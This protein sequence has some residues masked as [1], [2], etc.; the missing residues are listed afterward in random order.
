MGSNAKAAIMRIGL[1]EMKTFSQEFFKGV[2]DATFVSESAG[3]ADLITSCQSLYCYVTTQPEFTCTEL[4]GISGRN[5]KVADAFAKTG[6]VSRP[7]CM[8]FESYSSTER[9][10]S[11]T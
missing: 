2:K 4:T 10:R 8:T 6:K 5:R 9:S 3:V 11:K 1:M 7:I